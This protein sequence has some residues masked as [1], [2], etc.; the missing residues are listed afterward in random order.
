MSALQGLALFVVLM[1]VFFVL[2]WWSFEGG[3]GQ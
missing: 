3:R 2:G 1:V